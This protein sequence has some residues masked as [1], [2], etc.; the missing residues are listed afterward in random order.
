M[1]KKSP[2]RQANAWA[3]LSLAMGLSLGLAGPVMADPPNIPTT[4]NSNT[5]PPA[6]TLAQAFEQAWAQQAAAQA[7]PQ[8]RN[9]AQGRQ[10]AA[11]Q[12]LAD[13]PA[14]DL[15]AKTDRL[16]RNGGSRDY[17]AGLSLPLWL[18]GE[19]ARSQ[20]L[21]GAELN[22]LESQLAAERLRLAGSLR[23]AWWAWQL[24]KQDQRIAQARHAAAAQLAQDVAKRL[25][26]GDLTRA[27]QHQA[28]AAEAAA[29]AELAQAAVQRLQAEQALAAL[30]LSDILAN[31]AAELEAE[32][33]TE[34]RPAAMAELAPEHPA[35]LALR[36]RAALAQRNAEL[37]AT[38]TRANPE[39]RLSS[40]RERASFAEP[41]AQSITVGLR[42][43]LG[44]SA[45]S[46]SKQATALAEQLEA[47]AQLSQQSLALQAELRSAE[48]Q[49]TASGLAAEAAQRR[50]E[51]LAATRGFYAKS[52]A[53][54]QS[55]LPTRLRVEQEAFEAQRLS[56]RARLQAAQA[57][58]ALRQA[59][60]LLP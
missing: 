11:Q 1:S 26:A 32:A 35:L 10:Q 57:V 60:G 21:A 37:A 13:A 25:Q 22:A 14:L 38:Q 56:A 31:G 9:A 2:S 41:Y 18:P 7:A 43:P 24:S 40:T 8:W 15:S 53:L 50:A 49:L 55:D 45:A 20:A 46:Q 16:N 29:Q 42:L 48:A 58:S 19:R 51:L 33:L 36:D 59:Q 27:D 12:W 44:K 52:F 3:R 39:L 47:Q 6:A 4:P 54:G 30:G 17:E 5:S 28:Q 23:Q 34:A